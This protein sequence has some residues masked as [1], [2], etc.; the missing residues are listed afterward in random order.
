VEPDN[1]AV[2]AGQKIRVLSI[3]QASAHPDSPLKVGDVGVVLVIDSQRTVH[4]VWPGGRHWGLVPGLDSW[5]LVSDG[6]SGPSG[7][8]PS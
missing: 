8:T 1:P 6:N 5:E 3:G 2:Y 4:A 7:V